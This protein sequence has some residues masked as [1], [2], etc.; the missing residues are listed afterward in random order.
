[1][2]KPMEHSHVPDSHTPLPSDTMVSLL[3]YKRWAD[4]ELMAAALSLSWFGRL[5]VGRYV[6]AI[7]RHFHTVDCIFRAHLLGVSHGYTSAN[8]AEPATLAEL[9][10][11]V[12]AI[13][14]WYVAY[15][16]DLD[17]Q[18]LTERLHVTFTDGSQQLLTRSDM[19]L[20][21]AQH[22]AYHRGN[23]GILL[24]VAGAAALPDRFTSYLRQASSP[25]RS[26]G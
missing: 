4:A 6:A 19:L 2:L 17:G 7:I 1:M 5:L 26:A 15:A 3:R 16:Q 20:H 24:R 11:R 21:V 8:P 22:G 10:Q 12:R 14:D 23:L 18:R 9:Q 25:A 13:D